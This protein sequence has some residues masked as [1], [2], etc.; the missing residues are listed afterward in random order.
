M[1]ISRCHVNY[2]HFVMFITS[3][4][5]I[6]R[7]DS[8]SQSNGNKCTHKAVSVASDSTL[9]RCQSRTIGLTV[10][11]DMHIIQLTSMRRS[12][13]RKPRSLGDAKAD[14]LRRQ[15]ALHPHP[16][17][18]R[19]EA[20]RQDE[21]FDPRDLVQ[22]RYE[23]L[24][25]H[26][27]DR[28]A[29]TEVATAFGVSRQAYYMTDAA[30]EEKGIVGLLP[31][32]RG[33]RRAHKCTDEILDFVEQWRVDSSPEKEVSEAVRKRFGVSI[34]PRSLSRALARRKKKQR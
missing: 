11:L 3:M 17:A 14:V 21:F 4:P 7:S 9:R 25:R 1:A 26:Q 19:D 8:A 2:V 23:M 30:F 12:E 24:R 33:P 10:S 22:V 27:V 13:T 31:R 6:A 5:E 18:V 16:D 15:G 34:H 32:R 28:G 29:V 20:F